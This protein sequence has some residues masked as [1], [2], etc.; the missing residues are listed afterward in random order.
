MHFLPIRFCKQTN[1]L[2]MTSFSL[3]NKQQKKG[4]KRTEMIIKMATKFKLT[5]SILHAQTQCRSVNAHGFTTGQKLWKIRTEPL[6]RR[7][8]AGRG[9]P[10]HS[11]PLGH[12]AARLLGCRWP[13]GPRPAFSK[14]RNNIGRLSQTV[15]TPNF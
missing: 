15:H 8:I 5:I 7:A 2:I 9:L 13:L 1:K 6:G 11:R 10:D 12:Q 3:S 4:P 14:T